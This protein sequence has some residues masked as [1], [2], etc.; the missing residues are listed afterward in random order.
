MHYFQPTPLTTPLV[1]FSRVSWLAPPPS[2]VVETDASDV[3]W[4][5]QSNKAHQQLVGWSDSL[6]NRHINFRELYVVKLW[7]ER[8]PEL[9]NQC[10][11]FDIDNF[12]SV[13]YL[14]TQGATKSNALLSLSYV[15]SCNSKEFIPDGQVCPRH[16]ER[17]GKYT[18][19][20]SGHISRVSSTPSSVPLPG[21]DI[22]TTS[23]RQQPHLNCPCIGRS[24]RGRQRETQMRF[25]KIGAGGATF[26]FFP[27]QQ[28]QS[29][30]RSRIASGPSREGYS[31]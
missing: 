20:L 1:H 24:R 21:E 19:T 7:L 31:S 25:R 26:I 4:G 9:T 6:R 27:H 8:N 12:T 16:A 10:I 30:P 3:G 5:L 2:L 22:R 23:S 15:R 29:S 18:L 14:K 17:L 13:S 28:L 11:L